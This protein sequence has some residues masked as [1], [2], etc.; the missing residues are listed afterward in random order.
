MA[1]GDQRAE[2]PQGEETEAVSPE[3]ARHWTA[4]YQEL[5]GYEERI[6]ESMRELSAGMTAGEKEAVRKTN[7]EPLE[8]LLVDF[9]RRLELWRRRME[10]EETE[11]K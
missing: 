9:R 8:E 3:R 6:L 10:A 4:F 11:L 2:G 1:D 7:L 5:I